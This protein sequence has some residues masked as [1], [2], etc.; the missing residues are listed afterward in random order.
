[1]VEQLL[2]LKK[3][4]TRRVI[5]KQPIDIIP[6]RG[7]LACVRWVALD[8]IDPEP[9]ASIVGCRYGKPGDRLWVRET[10]GYVPMTAYRA[11]VG[12]V[13]TINPND[14]YMAAIYKAGFD[15]AG[16]FRW[17]PS[18]HM[19]RWAS[20]IILEI[21]F[22][23]VQRVQHITER[24]AVEEGVARGFYVRD[25]LDGQEMVQTSYR[26]GFKAKWNEINEK[27][28]FGWDANP[29]VWVIGF[30]VVKP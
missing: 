9:R 5:K 10:W 29:W 1:M 23:G 26:D 27:R 2:D 6:F 4:Q 8:Q 15:R 30:R 7:D 18:I 22:V 28:G 19:P 12:V 20:R 21:E 16:S 17:R 25:T 14:K 11:S 3:S 24:D 13:Q